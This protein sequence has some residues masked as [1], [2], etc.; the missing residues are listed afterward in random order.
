MFSKFKD[1]NQQDLLEIKIVDGEKE[2][3]VYNLNLHK[4]YEYF[5][6]ITTVLYP[7]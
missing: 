2:G 5:Y 3:L 7:P 1:H 6:Y 4:T